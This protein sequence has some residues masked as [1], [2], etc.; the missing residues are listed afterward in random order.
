[1]NQCGH[2]MKFGDNKRSCAARQRHDERKEPVRQYYKENALTDWNLDTVSDLL[3][4][5][6]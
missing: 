1:M 4:Y 2:Y 3:I 6:I 5:Y